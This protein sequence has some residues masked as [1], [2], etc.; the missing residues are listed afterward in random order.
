M[1][2]SL[3]TVGLLALWASLITVGGV[4]CDSQSHGDNPLDEASQDINA[5]SDTAIKA[6]LQGIL[7]GVEFISDS[8]NKY[9]VL[10][11]EATRG[12]VLTEQIVREKL[13][14]AVQQA[15][16]IRR[17]IGP[18]TCLA[19][20]MDVDEAIQEG[21]HPDPNVVGP[22]SY[23][24]LMLALKTMKSNLHSVVG[25][26]FGVDGNGNQDDEGNVAIV[27][28]GISK[29]SGKLIAILTEATWT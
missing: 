24:Q 27:Y 11:G 21:E 12:K 2:R 9:T 17:D 3:K 5:A 8:D 26:A 22:Q 13:R 7:Q 6:K 1:N 23:I 15:H 20:T 18:T 14:L 25:F 10:E 29:T 28:V 16:S 19:D 4:G